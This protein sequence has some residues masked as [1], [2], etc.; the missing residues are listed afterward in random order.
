MIMRLF[1]TQKN[2]VSL[3]FMGLDDTEFL[4]FMRLNDV[5]V[6]DYWSTD[7]PLLHYLLANELF[8]CFERF[9]KLT[10]ERINPDLCDG[11]SFG[12]KS[13][14]IILTLLVSNQSLVHEFIDLYKEKI[15]FDYQDSE[16]KTALHYAIILGR[17]DLVKHLIEVGASL[18]VQDDDHRCPKDYLQCSSK[19]IIDTLQK[20]DIDPYRDINALSNKLRDHQDRPLMLQGDHLLQNKSVVERVIRARVVLYLYFKDRSND[21]NTFVGDDSDITNEEMMNRAH[22]I[23]LNFNV[24]VS[25]VLEKH[26]LSRFE[27]QQF[28]SH[29]HQLDQ[30]F[31]GITVLDRCLSGHNQVV[32]YLL[33]KNNF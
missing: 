32:S 29:L 30:D 16:G 20:I 5:S 3:D 31:T 10:P 25:Q 17:D 23:A 26:K 7:N 4:K 19:V 13:L 11:K 22:E 6:N 28:R 33:V 15:N 14:L 8:S 24:S 1:I 21:W 18:D 2:I 27:Q 12:N 9:L